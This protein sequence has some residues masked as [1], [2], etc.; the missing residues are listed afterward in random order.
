MKYEEPLAM[1]EGAG[2]SPASGQKRQRIF[3]EFAR[4]EDI[5]EAKNDFEKIKNRVRQLLIGNCRLIDNKLE[6]P[7]NFEINPPANADKY[8]ECEMPKGTVTAGQETLI[9]FNFNPPQSDELLKNIGALKGIGQWI[10][11]VWEL[12]LLGGFIEP[13]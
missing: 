2:A 7:G 10:E 8:F 6:K 12:K 13:G 11:N 4:D 5:K 3:L 1:L 9:K